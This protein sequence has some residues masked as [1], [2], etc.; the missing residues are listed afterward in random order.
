MSE[1]GVLELV[2]GKYKKLFSFDKCAEGRHKQ[3]EMKEVAPAWL[4]DNEQCPSIS[5][6]T[7]YKQEEQK[8]QACFQGFGK[9]PPGD[10][11]L[12]FHGRNCRLALPLFPHF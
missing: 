12:L 4:V 3:R 10:W 11:W 5:Q 8:D 6:Q 9:L 2:G 1:S 7:N